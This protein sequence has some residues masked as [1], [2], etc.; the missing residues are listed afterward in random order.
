MFDYFL[1]EIFYCNSYEE[2]VVLGLGNQILASFWNFEIKQI[3]KKG[4]FLLDA[5]YSSGS[6]WLIH[7]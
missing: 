4:Y 5:Y 3:K 6:I 2:T 7:S 1:L